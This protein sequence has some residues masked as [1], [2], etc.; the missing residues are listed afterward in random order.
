MDSQ[1]LKPIRTLAFF[2][3][4]F[5]LFPYFSWALWPQISWQWTVSLED[6]FWA[7]KNTLIQALGSAFMTTL[8]GLWG[9]MGLLWLSSRVGEGWRRSIETIFILPSLLPSLFVIIACL[10]VFDPFPFSKVGVVIVH[11]LMNVGFVS[12]LFSERLRLKLAP[13]SELAF[14][15]G[16]RRWAFFKATLF[17]VLG[18]EIFYIFLFLFSLFLA[19]FSVPLMV[20]GASGTTFEVF[21]FEKLV[22]E[23][24]WSTAVGLSLLQLALL[25]GVFALSPKGLA[26]FR[27]NRS[28]SRLELLEAPT[29]LIFP[30]GAAVMILVTPLMSMKSGLRQLEALE[31]SWSLLLEPLAHT[32]ILSIS[33]GLIFLCLSFLIL[34]CIENRWSRRF[35]FL[36]QPPSTVIVGMSLFLLGQRLSWPTGVQLILGFIWIYFPA[37]FKMGLGAELSALVKLTEVSQ[38]LGASSWQTCKEVLFPYGLKQIMFMSGV[39]SLWVCGDFALSSILTT[40]EYH[41]A[42]WAKGLA[43]SYRLDAASLLLCILYLCSFLIFFGWRRLGNVLS[44]KY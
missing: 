22:I 38:V 11:T 17:G 27:M 5:F 6:I 12:Y 4:V 15:E 43:G 23:K 8:L 14:V 31:I 32:L 10:K 34:L 29:G 37:V 28:W 20:G 30:F 24:D 42:L 35:L 7:L 1:S 36:F 39:A 21:I 44:R 25:L 40:K 16:A 3:I 33:T 41:L 9:G 19:S 18:A 13:L 26:S 2:V